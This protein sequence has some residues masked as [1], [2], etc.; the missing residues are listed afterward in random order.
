ML[1]FDES[2][3]D[4]CAF[5]RDRYQDTHLYPNNHAGSCVNAN[6]NI[7]SI[8]GDR[9]PYN[10]CRNLEWQAPTVAALRSHTC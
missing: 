8:Y 5:E 10:L 1:G 9:M 3:D 2:I 6:H 4:F 7:L